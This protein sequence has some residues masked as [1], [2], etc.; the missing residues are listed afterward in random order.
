MK[1]SNHLFPSALKILLLV[2]TSVVTIATSAKKDNPGGPST[3][4]GQSRNY[5]VASS[6]KAEVGEEKIEVV[7]YYIV[8]PQE[9]DFRRY[10]LPTQFLDIGEDKVSSG[11]VNGRQ[12][13]CYYT[14][15]EDTGDEIDVYTC[16]E[17]S[18][19]VC[20]VT[21]EKGF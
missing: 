11:Q 13:D 19:L 15:L 18:Q 14:K 12:R 8:T 4:L 7:D 20:R 5:L 1:K 16:Y 9:T 3:T 6:C 2:L 21:F 10:G 17:F